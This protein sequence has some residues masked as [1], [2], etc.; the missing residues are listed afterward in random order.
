MS[1]V[2]LLDCSL[3]DGGY[4]NDFD[5]G[6]SNIDRIIQSL[7]NAG[8]EY[9]E[10]GFLED[11]EYHI[12][13]TMFSSIEQIVDLNLDYTAD[14]KYVVMT[15]LNH[16]NLDRLPEFVENT[17]D[18]IR[19]TFHI[20]EIEEAME[21]C[22]KIQ[23]KGYKVFS[24]PVGTTTYTDEQLIYLIGK[25]NELKPFA[26]SIVDTLGVMTRYDIRRTI[27][28]IDKRLDQDISLGFHS[29][30]NLQLSFSNSQEILDMDIEREIVIDS[31]IHGMGRGAGNLH[32]ELIAQYINTV[33]GKRYHISQLLHVIDSYFSFA[34]EKYEWGY[35]IP[36]FLAASHNC[37]PNY[38]SYL[39]SKKNLDVKIISTLLDL[40]PDADRG[41]YDHKLIKSI[42]YSYQDNIV[43]DSNDLKELTKTIGDKEIL[44]IA[45][46]KSVVENSLYIREYIKS[47]N[48]IVISINFIPE[49]FNTTYNFFS[50][51][52]RLHNDSK[53]KKE[54]LIL[55]SNIRDVDSNLV[56]NYASYT[57]NFNLVSDNATLMM[58]DILKSAGYKSVSLAGFDGYVIDKDAENYR[59]ESMET[60]LDSNHYEKLNENISKYLK[61]FK[62]EF[63][64][65]F[66]TKTNYEF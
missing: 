17:V 35:S 37:H 29:H 22:Q 52:R 12:D 56:F 64:L 11:C 58:L 1:N 5:F 30:N 40:I 23:D 41:M 6:K 14:S 16:L 33:D 59:R 66:I 31:T 54:K 47:N 36:Y 32:T 26:F 21:Y 61:D 44:L 15:R 42:Y 28:L 3:R 8:I 27:Q 46:G 20:G 53:Q 38:S 13:K 4:V 19:V 48:P 51:S 9:I 25:I 18:A 65:N 60:H 62:K 50:N 45:P 39:M 49:K 57:N 10:L 24:Q 55:T 63:K 2:K 43:D 34:K 7:T